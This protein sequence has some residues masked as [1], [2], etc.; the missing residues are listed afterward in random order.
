MKVILKI[1]DF[2]TTK[3][4]MTDLRLD[5]LGQLN[6]NGVAVVPSYV[7]VYVLESEHVEVVDP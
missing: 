5:V 1:N 2:M 4:K 7:E 3:E 6:S